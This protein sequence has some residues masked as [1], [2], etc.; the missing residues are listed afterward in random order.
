MGEKEEEE[1]EWA[2]RRKNVKRG[3]KGLG[4]EWKEEEEEEENK[5]K[6]RRKRKN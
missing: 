2:I 4:V 3:K 6:K 1:E 5:G